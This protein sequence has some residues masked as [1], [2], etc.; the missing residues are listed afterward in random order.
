[1]K[2]EMKIY[3]FLLMSLFTTI[4]CKKEI[5]DTIKKE[6][7]LG[8]WVNVNLNMDTLFFGDNS[9]KRIDTITMLW[10]H[11]YSYLLNKDSIK[12][13]YTGEYYIEVVESSHLI[14]LNNDK[15]VL[16][17]MGLQNYF[18]KYKGNQFRKISSNN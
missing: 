4:S 2:L 14:L 11:S 13:K 1:M 17:I 16:T 7:V 12:I 8:K 6:N 5:N 9:I 18:P 10:K 3:L 15:S